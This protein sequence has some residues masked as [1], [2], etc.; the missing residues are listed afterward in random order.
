[1]DRSLDIGV[2]DRSVSP[3]RARSRALYTV[4]V[5]LAWVGTRGILVSLVHGGIPYPWSVAIHYDPWL[6]EQWANS[7]REGLFPSDVTWQYPPAAALVILAPTLVNGLPY[8]H[9]FVALTAAADMVILAVLL[10]TS[11]RDGGSRLGVWLWVIGLP[12]LGPF[13]YGRYDIIVAALA[14]VT[15]ALAAHPIARGTLLGIG[16]MIKVWPAAIL[17]GL[18]RDR[19]FWYT[20]GTAGITCAMILVVASR[21]PGSL[22]FLANQGDRGI[23]VESLYATVFHV[24]HHLG[25]DGE[26]IDQFG[27]YEMVGPGVA[28]AEVAAHFVT[29]LAVGWLLLWRWRAN[30]GAVTPQ[31][32]ALTATL[33]MMAVSRVLSPQYFVWALA[34]GAI[35]ATSRGTSQRGVVGLLLACVALTHLLYPIFYVRML[36]WEQG[37]GLLLVARNVLFLATTIV[38]MTALWRSTG[39]P[40]VAAG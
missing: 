22:D 2:T 1:M 30:W 3:E 38:S 35:C 11:G 8:L 24:A 28:E 14:V 37:P 9:A 21:F 6:Y 12:L 20:A 32:A 39:R 13:A 23:Q 34:V 5:L 40:T 36:S 16:T 19:T 15:I 4:L 29:V 27:A 25:W 18:P 10:Q 31:D 26:M 17:V 33:L 7:L